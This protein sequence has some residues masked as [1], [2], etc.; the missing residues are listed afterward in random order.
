[1]KDIFKREI[2]ERVFI[3]DGKIL[4]EKPQKILALKLIRIQRNLKNMTMI[5]VYQLTKKEI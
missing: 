4:E 1:M 5:T 3:E 2:P